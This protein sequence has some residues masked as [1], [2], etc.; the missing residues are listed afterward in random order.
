[1]T[2]DK[3]E[4][5]D[6]L[7]EEVTLSRKELDELRDKA[8]KA[9]EHWDKILR[10][11]AEFENAKRRLEKRGRDLAAFANEKIIMDVL[12]VMDD[13]DRAIESFDS[14]HDTKKIREGLLIVQ[15]NFHKALGTHGVASIESVGKIFDPN[16]HEAIGEIESDG[17]EEGHVAEEIQKGYTLNGRLARASRVRVAKK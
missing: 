17:V 5:Q 6:N 15:N 3:Q 13:L 14:D 12:P 16:F 4:K 11:N 9:E 10:L 8:G 2:Q 7:S 1:M